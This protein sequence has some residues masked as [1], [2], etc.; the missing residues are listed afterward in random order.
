[1]Q[2][3]ENLLLQNYQTEFLDIAHTFLVQGACVI[4][5]CLNCGAPYIIL[6]LIAKRI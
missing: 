3:F 2:T 4:K 6:E 5:V 1:M